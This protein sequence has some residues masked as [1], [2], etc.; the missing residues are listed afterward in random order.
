[1]LLEADDH[2]HPIRRLL[3]KPQ[4]GPISDEGSEDRRLTQASTHGPR[5][6]FFRRVCVRGWLSRS[7]GWLPGFSHLQVV[8]PWRCVA[9]LGEAGSEIV[10]LRTA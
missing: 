6:E 7:S 1:M 8:E 9:E 5:V 10:D 2:A 4:L 3:I